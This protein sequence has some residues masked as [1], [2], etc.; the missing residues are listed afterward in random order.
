MEEHYEIRAVLHWL[1]HSFLQRIR[2]LTR[3][4]LL[5]FLLFMILHVVYPPIIEWINKALHFPEPSLPAVLS[6]AV[7][8]V[9]LERV[10]VLE[11]TLEEVRQERS[12]RVYAEQQRMYRELERLVDEFGAKR[13]VLIQ[14]S[15]STCLSLVRTLLAKGADVTVYIQS[16][17]T[18][19]AVGSSLQRGR[20]ERRRLDMINELAELY[21]SKKFHPFHY[22][23]PASIS[24]VLI[25]ES[26]LGIGWYIYRHIDDTNRR[27]VVTGDHVQLL[28]HNVPAILTRTGT[29]EFDL[30]YN[31]FTNTV[32][33][34]KNNSESVEL[35]EATDTQY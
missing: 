25:D 30:L 31:F 16:P 3:I 24:G 1:K 7:L 19:S 2:W 9:I 26:F 17:Q 35:H 14:Y 22:S 23:A 4:A 27:N 29:P 5:L 18:A 21:S 8:V 20:I 32:T 15:C 11:E 6:L 33:N 10:F 28:G 34:F 13:A 12:C